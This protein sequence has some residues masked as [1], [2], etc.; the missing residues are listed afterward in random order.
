[1]LVTVRA[2]FSSMKLRGHAAFNEDVELSTARVRVWSIEATRAKE[3]N[4]YCGIGAH[5]RRKG[6]AIGVNGGATVTGSDAGVRGRVEE[7]E[8][9][10]GVLGDHLDAV[11]GFGG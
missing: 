3:S 4:R 10:V 6:Y 1:M 5:K 2:P 8:D 11:D 9:E 7:I